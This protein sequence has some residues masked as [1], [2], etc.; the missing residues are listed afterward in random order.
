MSSQQNLKRPNIILILTDDQDI[1]LG[2][3]SL[4]SKGLLDLKFLEIAG[5]MDY[6]PETL[7]VFRENG[8]EFRHGYVTT[9]MC[10]PSRSSML[11]GL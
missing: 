8:V 7:K 4:N 3:N 9:P 11:T 6:M 2:E 10:C 5:S 1:E